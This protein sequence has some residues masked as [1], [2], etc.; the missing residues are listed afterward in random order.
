MGRSEF[1]HRLPGYVATGLVIL[2]T[3]LWTFWGVAEMY[4]EGW[5]LPFPEPMRYLILGAVCLALTL[6]ALTWPRFG[7]WLLILIGGA[8][9]AWWWTLA[10]GRG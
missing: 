5:G 7:G 9:T 1:K 2:T 3:A 6:V 10:A 8:F 4:Y